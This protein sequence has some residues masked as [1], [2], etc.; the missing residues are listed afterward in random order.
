M[1][2][3]IRIFHK[4][5][6]YTQSWMILTMLAI[7]VVLLFTLFADTPARAGSNGQQLRFHS[8]GAKMVS[9][10]IKEGINQNGKISPWS[11]IFQGGT[12][13]F[14]LANW[15]WIGDTRIDVV[16]DAGNRSV[17]YSCVVFVPRANRKSD[18]VDVYL[19]VNSRGKPICNWSYPQ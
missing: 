13:E 9:L 1:T 2:N 7:V 15:W 18:W 5:P 11:R 12:T 10:A 8:S 3:P 17:A 4:Q 14:A 16:L 6:R 19:G